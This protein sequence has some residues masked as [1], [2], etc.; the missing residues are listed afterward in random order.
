MKRLKVTIFSVLLLVSLFFNIFVPVYASSSSSENDSSSD[1]TGFDNWTL[2]DKASWMFINIPQVLSSMTGLVLSPGNSDWRDLMEDIWRDDYL[3][4][5]FSSYQEFLASKAHYNPTSQTLTFDSDAMEFLNK[6]FSSAKEEI[7]YQ[8]CYFANNYNLPAD[9]FQTKTASD[10]VHNLIKNNPDKMFSL[11]RH[12]HGSGNNGGWYVPDIGYVSMVRVRFSDVAYSAVSTQDAEKF[13]TPN[14]TLYNDDWQSTIEWHEF[15]IFD[16]SDNAALSGQIVYTNESGDYIT[17]KDKDSAIDFDLS[18][19][20]K[21]INIGVNTYLASL[22]PTIPASPFA[23]LNTSMV[24][25]VVFTSHN[26]AIPVFVSESAMKKGTADGIQG[27]YMPGYTGQPITNNTI[28]Q[29]EINDFSQNYNNY[30]GSGSGGGG[31]GD[32]SSSG[33][34]NWLDSLLSALGK[35]GDIVMTLFSKV[36]DIVTGI[37]KFFTDTLSNAMDIIPSGFVGFLG[38][39]FPFIPKEWLTAVSLMLALLLIGTAIKVFRK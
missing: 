27:Q 2:A 18:L 31:S 11:S 38:A 16:S 36:V 28:S 34:G 37:I 20:S 30:Y 7:T 29:K 14:V 9:W 17:I 1:L 25:S 3:S 15:I 13:G 26:G 35:L 10:I 23:N 24:Q 4:E 33:S 21:T 32:N 12:V 19:A 5:N 8:D 39:L 6:V 22:N